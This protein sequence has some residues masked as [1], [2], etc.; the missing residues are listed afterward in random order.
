MLTNDQIEAAA[1]AHANKLADPNTFAHSLP[2]LSFMSGAQWA[3][4]QNAK[5]IEELVCALQLLCDEQNGAP[6]ERRRAQ[7]ELAM[8]QAEIALKKYEK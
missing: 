7:W 5:A 2:A 4:K 3:N 1:I 8:E 6:L